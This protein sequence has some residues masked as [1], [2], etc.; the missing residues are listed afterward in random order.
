[1]TTAGN[2]LVLRKYNGWTSTI[3]LV[4]AVLFVVDGLAGQIGKKFNSFE[5]VAGETVL[6]AEAMP[7]NAEPSRI[8]APRAARKAWA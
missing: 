8:C 5:A 1:V 3:L 2:I 4:L 7:P 6:M